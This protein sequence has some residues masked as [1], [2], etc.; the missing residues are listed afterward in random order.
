MDDHREIAQIA[1]IPGYQMGEPKNQTGKKQEY[2][3]P[4]KSPEQEFLPG[5]EPGGR[6]NLLVFVPNVTG[7]R[8]PERLVRFRL[9]HLLAPQPIHHQSPDDE[10]QPRPGMQFTGN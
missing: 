6:R 5:I 2:P 10:D 4:E 9:A 7:N 1:K 8:A 3:A